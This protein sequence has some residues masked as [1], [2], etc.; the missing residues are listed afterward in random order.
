MFVTLNEKVNQMWMAMEPYC[1]TNEKSVP[2]GWSFCKYK[3]VSRCKHDMC[4]IIYNQYT[5]TVQNCTTL[6]S[7]KTDKAAHPDGGER[8]Q[9]L[10]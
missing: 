6:F 8:E 4:L 5:L 9:L 2:L 1:G 3:I 7:E 10:L